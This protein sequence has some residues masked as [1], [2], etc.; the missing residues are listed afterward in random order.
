MPRGFPGGS[1]VKNLPTMQ[2]IWVQF[3]GL[4]DYLEKEIPTP[5][6]L[7]EKSHGQRGLMGYSPWC[8]KRVGHDLATTHKHTHDSMPNTVLGSLQGLQN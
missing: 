2:E 4:E 6:F 1:A 5:V 3:L 7:P 8:H